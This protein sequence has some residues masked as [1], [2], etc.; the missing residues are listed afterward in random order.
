MDLVRTEK[1]PLDALDTSF[2]N[3]VTKRQNREAIHMENGMPD[4]AF[5]L[6]YEIRY[7]LDKIPG[8]RSLCKRICSTLETRQIH[9]FNQKAVA[10]G[11]N[12]Y[13]DI[14]KMGKECADRL[15][16]GIPNIFIYQQPVMN[17]FTYASDDVSPL[18]VLYTGIIDRLNPDEVR[19]VIAH[20]CGHIHNQHTIYKNVI[21]SLLGG[22][23]G[24]IGM[25]L[26]AA[27]MALMQF[28]IR[29]SEITADRAG[30]ICGNRVEDSVNVQMKLLSGATINDAFKEELDI[31]ELW[32]QLKETFDNPTRVEEILSDHPSSLRRI[33]CM[34]EFAECDVFYKWRSELKKPGIQMKSKSETDARCQKL[35]N[36]IS[37]Q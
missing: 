37:N 21:S 28:W 26:S 24:A 9:L 22:N 1:S 25:L 31:E 12:Q 4:Y 16:I 30:M 32:R 11:P 5:A 18:I 35:I 33:F 8:F 19:C 14:Y 7:R 10:V 29:A 20:E 34:K 15:G 3:Y 2:R 36:I 17:A 23:T 13:S 27:N 6:D